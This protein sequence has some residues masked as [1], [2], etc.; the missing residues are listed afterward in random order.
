[1]NKIIILFM[2]LLTVN[3]YAADI[4]S[5]EECIN[6]YR[7]GYIDLKELV[8]DFNAGYFSSFGFASYVTSNSTG[9]MAHRAACA[10]VENPSNKE[11]VL[12]YKKLYN[13]LRDRIKLSAIISGNQHK[14]TY[15]DQ[16]Q[17][18]VEREEIERQ[19]ETVF[20]SIVNFFRTGSA[21]VRET[22]EETRQITMLEYVDS[23]CNF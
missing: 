20:G 19:G 16:M 9:I 13:D 10:V 14:I 5:N 17:T 18:V 6:V 3:T 12:S 2:T 22:I 11:C 23:K 1:M 4:L 7:E 15:T 21:T 8:E